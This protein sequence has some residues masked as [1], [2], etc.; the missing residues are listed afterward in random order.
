M[1]LCTHVGCVARYIDRSKRQL[2][3]RRLQS[4]L[5]R[6]GLGWVIL[7]QHLNWQYYYSTPGVQTD[8]VRSIGQYPGLNCTDSVVNVLIR[9]FHIRAVYTQRRLILRGACLLDEVPRTPLVYC[10]CTLV[11]RGLWRSV[12]ERKFGLS[13][14]NHFTSDAVQKCFAPPFFGANNFSMRQPDAVQFLVCTRGRV[15]SR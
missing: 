3:H 9:V 5:G 11:P 10:T 2:M 13:F 15:H 1:V 4:W 8:I 6:S 7:F 14:A 12:V